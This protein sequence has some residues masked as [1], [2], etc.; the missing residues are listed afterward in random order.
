[1]ADKHAKFKI[2]SKV[3][4]TI[5]DNESNFFKVFKMFPSKEKVDRPPRPRGSSNVDN[6]EEV[7]DYLDEEDEED[8]V[9]YVDI[10]EILDSHYNEA[11]LSM[12]IE[13]INGLEVKEKEL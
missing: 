2:T 5:T 1:M 9:V 13:E 6:E 3:N 8:D 10:G 7:D 12:E 11:R 4:C